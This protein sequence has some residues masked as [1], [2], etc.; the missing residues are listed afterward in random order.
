MFHGKPF[1]VYQLLFYLF[2]RKIHFGL[3]ADL[4][5]DNFFLSIDDKQINFGNYKLK[6]IIF[7]KKIK[8][9][10]HVNISKMDQCVNRMLHI[11]YV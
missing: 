5:C 2:S 4:C 7:K 1:L 8:L 10:L 11:L 6:N 3:N 9:K